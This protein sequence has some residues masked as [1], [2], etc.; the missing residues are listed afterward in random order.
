MY[1]SF[2]NFLFFLVEG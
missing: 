2:S 1:Y